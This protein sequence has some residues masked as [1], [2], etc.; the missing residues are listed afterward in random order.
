MKKVIKESIRNSIF[1]ALFTLWTAPI[2]DPK[3]D[4]SRVKKQHRM[5][6]NW[7]PN[8]LIIGHRP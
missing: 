5:T 1:G 7:F 8:D 2:D 3:M 4:I 6:S